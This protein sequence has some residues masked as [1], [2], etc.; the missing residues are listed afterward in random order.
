MFCSYDRRR[1]ANNP[2]SSE[3]RKLAGAVFALAWLTF[4]AIS[5]AADRAMES[6][7]PAAGVYA[8]NAGVPCAIGAPFWAP[9]AVTAE[10]LPWRNVWLGHFSGGR[11]FRDAY[12]VTLVD[13]LDEKVCF[14]SRQG[15]LAWIAGLRRVYH[16]T[17]GFWTCL[18]LR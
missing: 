13:W 10:E 17:E 5:R 16:R 12:G 9:P 18:V 1:K 8:A 15:C 4:P 7:Q 2:A 14:P 6:S 11:H 3:L